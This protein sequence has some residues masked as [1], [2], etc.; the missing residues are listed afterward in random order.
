M[1]DRKGTSMECLD[2]E[3]DVEDMEGEG[4]PEEDNADE[5]ETS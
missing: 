5:G 4:D 3:G 2:L 1:L